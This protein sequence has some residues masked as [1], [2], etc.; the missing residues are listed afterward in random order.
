ME[1]SIEVLLRESKLNPPPILYFTF[2]PDP[3]TDWCEGR[4]DWGWFV[5]VPGLEVGRCSSSSA[6][7]PGGQSS[8]L[9]AT[10]SSC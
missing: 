9:A 10:G 6:G 1:W 4:E 2:F 8:P 3:L 7:G 5:A